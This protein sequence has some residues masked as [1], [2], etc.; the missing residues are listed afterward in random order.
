MRVYPKVSDIIGVVFLPA[1]LV[2]A[3]FRSH[4]H[5]FTHSAVYYFIVALPGGFCT[6]ATVVKTAL[7]A[8]NQPE[9]MKTVSTIAA[10]FMPAVLTSSAALATEGTN[11]WFGVDDLRLLAVL[12]A[13][14]YFILSLWLGQYGKATEDD[15][16][17][18]FGE[19]DYTGR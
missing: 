9:V 17:D 3:D 2:I 5:S 18:F 15:D 10:G 14:H 7:S 19:I 16:A 1:L 6:T 8:A 11:E 4:G 13:G 12:F